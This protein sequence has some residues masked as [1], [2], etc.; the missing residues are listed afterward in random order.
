M[1][2]SLVYLLIWQNSPVNGDWHEQEGGV[3]SW[4]LPPLRQIE[5][6]QESRIHNFLINNIFGNKLVPFFA[7]F[8]IDIFL[9]IRPFTV[10]FLSVHT[11][12]SM[13]FEIEHAKKVGGVYISLNIV[14]FLLHIF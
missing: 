8:F 11:F 1:F 13:N 9:E 6:L 12:F 10:Y 14:C 5:G 3:P 2:T 4:Q 7:F